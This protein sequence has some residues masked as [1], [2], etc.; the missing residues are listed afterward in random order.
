MML[1]NEHPAEQSSAELSECRQYRYV[2]RRVWDASKAPVMFIGLNP[3]TAD[4]TEDDATICKCRAYAK[5]WGFGGLFMVNVFAF[6]ARHPEAMKGAADPIGPI[7][8]EVLL[9]QAALAGMI[10]A[11]WGAHGAHRNGAHRVQTLLT[12]NGYRLHYLDLTKDGEPRHPL[13]LPGDL[14]P[15][16]L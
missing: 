12:S 6:R 16:P 9:S 11:A 14:T 15:K 7:N 13:Y 3:S 1:E 5:R 2:L 4:E 10:I 8:D